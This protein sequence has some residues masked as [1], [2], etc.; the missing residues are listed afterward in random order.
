MNAPDEIRIATLELLA[1]IGVPDAE[2]EKP[3]R[4]TVS[5]TMEPVN[6][7]TALNDDLARTLDY[8]SVAAA[9]REL[10]AARPRRLIETLAEEI[11]QLV[12]SRFQCRHVAIELRKY[13]LPETE[14]VSVRLRRTKFPHPSRTP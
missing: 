5:L 13:I 10:A 11:A 7:F 9:I 4:L 8:A 3:Q 12:L 6:D 14:Y 2:R 1:R